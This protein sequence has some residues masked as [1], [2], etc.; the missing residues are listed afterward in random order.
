MKKLF[1]ISVMLQI[2]LSVYGPGTPKDPSE[3][4]ENWLSNSAPLTP[5]TLKLAMDLNMIIAPDVVMAQ[6]IL[7]TGHYKSDLYLMHNNLFGMKKA[8][9]RTTTAIGSTENDYASYQTWYDSVR[10]MRLF[11]QWYLSRGRDLS[12]YLVFLD[13]IGYAEDP[14]YIPKIEKLCSRLRQ[15]REHSGAV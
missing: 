4:L 2:F 1:L 7:E 8:R 3:T 6:S 11:Q 13:T 15:L 5:V 10:D 14:L 12:D 9:V